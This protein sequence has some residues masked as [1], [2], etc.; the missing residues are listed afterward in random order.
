MVSFVYPCRIRSVDPTLCSACDRCTDLRAVR[1][2]RLE[3]GGGLRPHRHHLP[4][5]GGR[6]VSYG[7]R[8]TGPRCATRSGRRRSTSCTGCWTTRGCRP[9]SAACCSP[10]TDRRRGTA[11]GRSA[12]VATSGS[13]ASDGYKYAE[14]ETAS[15]DRPGQGRAAAH[16]RGAA[17]DPVHAEGGDLRRTR[18]G[19]RWWAQ[20]ARGVRPDP[21][22]RGTCP[23]Q[24]DRRGRGLVRRR[25]RFG[26]P[27]PAGRAEVRPRDLLP[28]RGV[29]RRGRVP[30]GHGEPGRAARRAGGRSRWT[31]AGRSAP[32]RR[33]RSGC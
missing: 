9:T 27:G 3:A 20:P 28:R 16:P 26:V 30:D 5:C 11:A 12:P 32:S 25:V 21:G 33:P 13:G 15:T 7:S 6:R 24:A 10:A 22:V 29:R 8:S 4:P 23:V 1:P 31:G 2:D 14:G 18:L 17:A 19:R